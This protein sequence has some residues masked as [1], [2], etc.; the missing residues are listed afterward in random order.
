MFGIVLL[1]AKSSQKATTNAYFDKNKKRTASAVLSFK[2]RLLLAFFIFQILNFCTNL[3]SNVFQIL[4]S[5]AQARASSTIGFVVKLVG[6]LFDRCDHSLE[7][8][9][10]FHFSMV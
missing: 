7:F 6:I 3:L 2:V 8:F 9:E 1:R 10:F 5:F 4:H